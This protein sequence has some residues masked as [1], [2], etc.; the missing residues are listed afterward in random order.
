MVQITPTLL[1]L[2]SFAV[3]CLSTTAANV[4]ADLAAISTQVTTLDNA[5][6]AFPTSGGSL[7]AALAIH[8]DAGNLGTAIDKGTTDTNAVVPSPVSESDGATILKAVQAFEPE[9]LHALQQIILKKPG[10]TS[11]PIGGIP[12][13]VKQ[14]LINLNSSTSKFEAA[15][16]NSA[17]PDL[18]AQA[19]AIKSAVDAALASA[20]AAY[21]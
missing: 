6:T 9:I 13:L 5:I 18:K 3:T 1:V 10:F 12:A 15:L 16:I 14:D 11:L 20:V 2:L 7:L 4:E 19:T 8:T 17:P 21:S